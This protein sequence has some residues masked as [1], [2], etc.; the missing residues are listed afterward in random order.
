MV[1]TFSG[2]LE[3][4][5]MTVLS[6]VVERSE[7]GPFARICIGTHLFDSEGD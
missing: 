2:E 7:G 4:Y 6:I 3:S 5:F 1:N